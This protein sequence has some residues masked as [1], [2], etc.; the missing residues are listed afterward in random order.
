MRHVAAL[1]LL[2]ILA[3]VPVQAQTQ[4]PDLP[5]PIKFFNTFDV[6]ANT[7]RAVL[8]DMEHKIELDDRKSGKIVTRPYEIIT[9]SLTASEVEKVAVRNAA[10]TG[11]L[12]KARYS[13]D[14]IIEIVSPSETLVTIHT[15]IQALSREVDGTEKWVALDSLGTYERRILGR[16]STR[17]MSN[18][19]EKEERK[20]FWGQKPKPVDPR[21][22]RIPSMPPR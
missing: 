19:G 1:Q 16:V 13:V 6:V 15:T 10:I 8:L 12:V 14:A 2:G 11:I 7:V 17:L 22:P 4:K 21:Q 9:G 18:R 5:D 20:G 3:A